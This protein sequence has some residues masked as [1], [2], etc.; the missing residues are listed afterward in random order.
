MKTTSLMLTMA[1]ALG[2]ASFTSVAFADTLLVD[3]VDREVSVAKP[4]RGMSMDAVAAQFGEPQSKL[5]PVGGGHP[6]QPPITRWI[7]PEFTV[8]FE[9]SH[10]VDAVVNR[11][12]ALEQPPQ[13]PS[14]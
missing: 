7:Y 12:T 1:V 13:S 5:E 8:Y 11:T 10:V 4:K 6:S 9:H 14:N 3:R 2:V